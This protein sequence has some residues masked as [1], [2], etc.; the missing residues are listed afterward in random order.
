MRRLLAPGVSEATSM[1]NMD[2]TTVRTAL[3]QLEQAMLDHAAWHENLLRAIVCGLPFN[4]GDLTE[5]AHLHCRFSRWYYERAPAELWGQRAFAAIGTEH[6]RLHRIA[7]R[8][9]RE[10]AADA[11]IVR[12]DFEDLVA[13]SARLRLELESL[14]SAM[15]GALRNRDALTGAYDRA[16]ML[17]DLRERHELAARRV[18]PCCIAFMDIDHLKQ[19]NDTHGH[20]VGDAVLAGAVR[21]LHTHLR[22]YDKVF[23]YGGDEF[24]IV[25]PGTD[26]PICQAVIRRVR[27][28][29]A[30]EPRIVGPGGIELR[31]TASFGLAL[32]DPAVAVEESIE[33]ADQALLLAKTAGRNSAI[34]WDPNVTT[35]T[36]LPRLRLEDVKE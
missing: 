8:L 21:Y 25:L 28:G 23:R 30:G 19:V 15:L 10:V 9:L 24:L 29:L 14:R 26:L 33:R 2:P 11:P 3:E 31:S 7:A 6:E 20:A 16:E 4:L 17:P 32:L 13:G 34:S 35:G 12:Q 27:E 18:Q 5:S 36:R 22:P 1:L